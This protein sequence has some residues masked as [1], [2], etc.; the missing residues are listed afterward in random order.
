VPR[1]VVLAFRELDGSIPLL[2]WLEALPP[3]AAVRC[4][5]KIGRLAALGHEIRRPEADYLRDGVYEIRSSFGGIHYRMLYFFAARTTVIITH[6]LV[7]ERVVPDTEIDRAI[8]RRWKF[9]R[10]SM[11]HTCEEF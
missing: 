1:V 6:G 11:R 5:A 7:K 9:H 4:R 3:K 8:L 2:E 10:D